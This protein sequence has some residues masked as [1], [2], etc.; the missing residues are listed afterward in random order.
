MSTFA[1]LGLSETLCRGLVDLAHVTPT[2]V[3]LAAIPPALAGSDVRASAQT[4]SGKTAA[5]IL[6]ILEQL[7]LGSRARD[8]VHALIIAPTR[9]LAMQI[10]DAAER[11]G[12]FMPRAPKIVL[13]TGGA[14]ANPQMQDLRGGADIV[15]ATPGR[16]LDLAERHALALASVR[17]LVLDEADRL[18]ALGFADDLQRIMEALPNE[19]QVL[20]FSATLPSKVLALA[21]D[22]LR[23][24]VCINIDQGGMPGADI[25]VQRAIE[26]DERNRTRLLVHL[27]ADHGWSQVLVFVASREAADQLAA[28]LKKSGLAAAALHGELSQNARTQTLADFKAADVQVLV[29]TDLAARGLDV[30]QLPAVVN[31]DLPRSPVDYVHRIGRTGRAGEPGDA[32]SFITA[33]NHAHFALIEKRHK[34]ALPRERIKDYEPKEAPESMRDGAG[35]V[36]GKRKSKKDKLREAAAKNKKPD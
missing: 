23:K 25:I 14:A 2:P 17:T 11:Y 20:L 29:A 16:L 31:F 26:V 7:Q 8:T 15:V 28:T 32:L 35:G 19:M 13:I 24:P 21:D 1:A 30:V 36:K 6:P 34:L 5:F 12:A 18:L 10:A 33:Q 3:Q 22:I 27:I 9:E 4:G